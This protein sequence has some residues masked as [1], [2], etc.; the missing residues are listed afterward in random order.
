MHMGKVRGEGGTESLFTAIGAFLDAHGL[1]PDPEHYSFA[2]AALTDPAIAGAVAEL[3]DGQVRLGRRGIEALGGSV[4]PRRA[5][6]LTDDR[7]AADLVAQTQA[8]VDDFAHL[9]RGLQAETIDFGRD[10]AASAAAIRRQPAI[11]GLDEIARIT[12]AMTVRVRDAEARLATATAEAEALRTELAHAQEEARRDP[13]TGLPNRLAFEEAF[14]RLDR[15]AGP[16]CLGVVD[17]DH[18]KRLNDRH[19]HG[20]GDRVLSAIARGLEEA[21]AGQLVARHG[22]EEFAVLLPAVTLAG[23]GAVLEAARAA[24]GARRFRI[25]DS[26]EAVGRITLSAGVVEVAAGERIEDAFARADRLL[27]A[28]KAQGRDQVC[29]G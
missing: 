17:I 29:I 5:P 1:G 18:F 12:G 28:A 21:C 14:A 25:R 11:A 2:H 10:L 4:R 15:A 3:T 19:G 8:Q 24:L 22:G 9:M 13:L 7:R 16:A 20:V 23:A 26:G 27:Y 6:E